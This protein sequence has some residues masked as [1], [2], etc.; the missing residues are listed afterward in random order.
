MN[1]PTLLPPEDIARFRT[2]VLGY[3]DTARRDVPWRE[4]RDPY[5]VMVSEFMLQQTRTET[6]IPYFEEWIRAFPDVERLAHAGPEDVLKRWE[7]LGYYRRAR[8]LHRS[9]REIVERHGGRVPSDPNVLRTLPGIGEYTAGAIASIAFDVATPAIDGNVRRVMARLAD[10]PD[11]Q[12]TLLRAWTSALVDL[13]RPGAFNQGLMELGSRVCRPRGPHCA[14]C[15]VGDWCRAKAAGT[16]A[17]R[18][19]PAKR[20]SVPHE[21]RGVAVLVRAGSRGSGHQILLRRRS[22]DGLLGGLW[23]MPS[24]VAPDPSEAQTVARA[25]A[26]SLT[27]EIADDHAAPSPAALAVVRHA[28]SHLS[29]TYHPFLFAIDPEA[30][31]AE[32]GHRWTAMTAV[33]D[34]PIPVAQR[35]ILDA[36]AKTLSPIAS[37]R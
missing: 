15:P 2:A 22:D 31:T 29:V 8:N 12:P 21:H 11:P 14:T 34:L 23:E 7:G 27:R 4:D 28:F 1:D 36:V 26:Y 20:G 3:F 16:Q 9:A 25:L 30:P 24:A 35:K 5:R 37:R 32:P 6:V 17:D 33:A 18:P 19:R 10:D 13:D